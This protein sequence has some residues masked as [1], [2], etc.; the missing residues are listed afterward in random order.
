MFKFKK[1]DKR[2]IFVFIVV[3]YLNGMYINCIYVK[4]DIIIE[5]FIYVF[6][7]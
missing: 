1:K 7:Y 2:C 3:Y 5:Y 6:R 4:F